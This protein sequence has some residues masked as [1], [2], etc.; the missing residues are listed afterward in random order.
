MDVMKPKARLFQN[1]QRTSG[2]VLPSATI[3][4]CPV[5]NLGKTN[6]M[7]FTCEYIWKLIC[8][9]RRVRSFG[10]PRL[11]IQIAQHLSDAN[12]AAGEKLFFMSEA[13]MD[14]KVYYAVA[15]S[16]WNSEECESFRDCGALTVING[17]GEMVPWI[18]REETGLF[19]DKEAML[20]IL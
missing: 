11:G 10:L 16:E 5:E 3:I 15:G 9:L 7:C 13:V 17:C 1:H 12:E 20:D 8:D 6:K 18:T 4:C 2:L 14:G 19:M